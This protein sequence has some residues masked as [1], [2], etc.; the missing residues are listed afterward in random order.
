MIQRR[1]CSRTV[2]GSEAM[3]CCFF[4]RSQPFTVFSQVIASLGSSKPPA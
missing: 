1:Y 2:S 3:S 4:L